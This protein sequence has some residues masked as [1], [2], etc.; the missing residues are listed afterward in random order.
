MTLRRALVKEPQLFVSTVVEKLMTYGL[1]R[2][3]TGYDIPTV[4][5][6]RPAD[7]ATDYKFRL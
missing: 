4:R 1:G 6:I 2:G 3:V 5:A 7:A